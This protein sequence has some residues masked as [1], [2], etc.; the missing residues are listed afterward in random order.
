MS[1]QPVDK[2][3]DEVF[4]HSC[5]QVIKHDA[6]LCPHCG[7]PVRRSAALGSPIRKDKTVALLLAIFL[8]F[9]TWVYTYQVDA[10]K[11]WLNLVL[12][13][14]TCGIWWLGAWIWAIIDVA[15]RPQGFYDNFPYG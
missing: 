10:W 14:V 3:T 7:V 6:V 11:F 9:W 5:G 2:Q 15:V 8:A 1:Q 12:S 13:V 4:C